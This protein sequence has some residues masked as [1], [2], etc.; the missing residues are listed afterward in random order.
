[1]KV[2]GLVPAAL[3][4]PK[5]TDMTAHRR[6]LYNVSIINMQSP[7][8]LAQSGPLAPP[9]QTKRACADRAGSM[10]LPVLAPP[11]CLRSYPTADPPERGAPLQCSEKG[12]GRRA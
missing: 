5:R 2:F 1:M 8:H 3:Q 9:A 7:E 12:H 10:P 6:T 4:P 11:A